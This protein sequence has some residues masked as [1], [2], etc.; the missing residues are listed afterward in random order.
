MS[1]PETV[2]VAEEADI[3]PAAAGCALCSRTLT[4]EITC[5]V[6]GQVVCTACAE[7]IQREVRQQIAS[8]HTYL[9]AAIGGLLGAL[10]G[11]A[12]WAA[13]VVLSNYE[14]GYVAVLVGFLTGV[15]VKLGARRARS[16]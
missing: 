9:T 7:Q 14:V 13:I 4:P 2:S 15:G 1:E 8:G 12:I 10:V 11:A 3:P 6:N 5:T 16:K